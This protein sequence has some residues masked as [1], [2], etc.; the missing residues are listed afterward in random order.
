MILIGQ[1]MSLHLLSKQN[2]EQ[3][4]QIFSPQKKACQWK[5]HFAYLYIFVQKCLPIWAILCTGITC[6]LQYIFYF[7]EEALWPAMSFPRS[8][9]AKNP[10]KRKLTSLLA[11]V[12]E[13]FCPKRSMGCPIG[14]VNIPFSFR[15]NIADFFKFSSIIHQH[16][17]STN[18]IV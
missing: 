7:W 12:P 9:L 11:F 8:S 5:W 10:L 17:T 18:C 4:S 13:F 15:P 3:T 6:R 2:T 1:I 14:S 16:L